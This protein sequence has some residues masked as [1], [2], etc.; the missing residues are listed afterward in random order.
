MD[1]ICR[2]LYKM[3]KNWK[4]GWGDPVNCAY[5]M[6][7]FASKMSKNFL[8]GGF[9][10]SA[11]NLYVIE[12]NFLIFFHTLLASLP[13]TWGGGQT[14][15]KPLASGPFPHYMG[16]SNKFGTLLT[17][18]PF[19]H[20]M[21]GGQT[22]LKPL[23]SGPFPHYMGGSNKFGTLLTSGPFPHYMGGVKPIWSPLHQVPSPITWE[24]QTN[25]A[26]FLHQAPSPIKC[27]CVL[28]LWTVGVWIYGYFAIRLTV[29]QYGRLN[30]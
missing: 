29:T 17:S 3:A 24:G 20:Y 2:K 12:I 22:N 7:F 10:P 16:G 15:L 1:N 26:P 28:I 6:R 21:G 9:A 8:K 11:R 27:M 25:L 18:G 23:A 19:P 5:R 4:L 30:G 13:I 14:N